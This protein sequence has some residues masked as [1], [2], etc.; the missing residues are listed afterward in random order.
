MQRII[1]TSL[2]VWLLLVFSACGAD[3]L[4]VNDNPNVATRPPLDG[5]MA[6]ASLETAENHQSVSVGSSAYFVQYLAS[7]NA[8]SST[9]VYDQVS[10]GGAWNAIYATM[11][12]LYDL[13]RFGEED[14]LTRH[15]AIAKV[16][17]AVN[18]GLIVDN[19]G[20]APYSDAF[21]GLELR[22]TYDDASTLYT[23]IFSLL[24]EAIALMPAAAD[25][26][27]VGAGSDFIY[28]GDLDLWTK[29]AYSLRARYLNHLSETDQYDPA[30]VL[31]AVDN[32]FTSY[33]EDA[34]VTTFSTRN[35]WAQVAVSNAALVLGGWLSE[36]FVDALNGTTYGTFDPRLPLLTNDNEEGEYVGTPNGE[37]RAGTGTATSESYLVTEGYFSAEDAPLDIITFAE[38]KLIEAEAALAQSDQDRADTAFAAAVT[39]S[40]EEIGVA[41]A[42]I[43]AYLTAEY[44]DAVSRDDIFREKYVALFLSPETWVDARR[45]DYGYA[46]FELPAGAEL[47]AFP[48]RLMYPDTETNRNGENV[49][50]VDMLDPIFWDN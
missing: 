35:P 26:P 1:Q 41:A 3:Y 50:E 38:L 44:P 36:Q 16:M 47:S 42:D 25:A 22:P 20:D 15:V 46:D 30:A 37:G 43:E 14:G 10:N 5:L 29:A 18:L 19:W 7:P 23:T 40:M 49:P 24:D 45:Y 13:V 21:T 8:G 28:N 48:R 32:G 6:T 31:T 39:A 4:N 2:S 33:E 11:T 9:D 34:D 17:M 27:E 12:D